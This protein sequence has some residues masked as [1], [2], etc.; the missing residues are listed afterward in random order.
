M[1]AGSESSRPGRVLRTST[2]VAS[3]RCRP[4]TGTRTASHNPQPP[5]AD[6]STAAGKPSPTATTND[7]ID[8]SALKALNL[9]GA[10]K[11]L[12]DAFGKPGQGQVLTR[13]SGAGSGES[14]TVRTATRGGWAAANWLVTNASSY[15]ITQVS[16]AGYQWTAGLTENSWQTDSR[17]AEG[18][19]V[20]S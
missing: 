7:R 5:P 15:G 8:L 6:K 9:N 12:E 18:G 11:G 13:I 20:A 3:Q 17:A 16:Y 1:P 10:V 14:A 19:I 4:S 2:S